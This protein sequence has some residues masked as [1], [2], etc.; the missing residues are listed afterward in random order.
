MRIAVLILFLLASLTCCTAQSGLNPAPGTYALDSRAQTEYLAGRQIIWAEDFANGLASGW[1]SSAQGNVASWEFRGPATV[2]NLETGS[3]GSC[4]VGNEGAPI[5]SPTAA[6]GFIIF[7]SNWWDNPNLPCSEDNFGTGPAPGPHYATL[8]SPVINLSAYSSVA[9]QFNQYLK[10]LSGETRI[11]VTTDDINWY[12]VY[13]NPDLP[14]P[15]APNDVRL[16]QISNYAA[17]QPAVRI[18]FVFDAQYYFWQLDDVKI[19]ETATNDLEIASFNYG[20]FD[21]LNPT[22]PTGYEYMQ[23]SKYP[24]SMPPN[25]KFSAI[26]VNQGGGVQTDCRLKVDVLSAPN[27]NVL[28]QAM[29]SEGFFMYP[30]D[31]IEL[32]AGNYQMEPIAGE[33]NLAFEVDQSEQDESPLNNRD[34]VYFYI[35]DVQYARDRIFASAVYLGTPDLADIAYELGNVFLIT[36]PDQSCHSITVGIGI[37]SSTPA[38][39][40]G[41]LYR[42][43]LE[44][45]VEADLLGETAPVQID[46]SMFNGYGDQI[47][48][49]LTFATPIELFDGEAYFVA[50]ASDNG[51]D[52]FVCAMAGNAEEGTA[53]VRYFPE[54]WYYLDMLPMVRM[55]FGAFNTVE[56]STALVQQLQVFPNPATDAVTITVPVSVNTQLTASWYDVTG[57]LVRSER[58]TANQHTPYTSSLTALAPGLYRIILSDHTNHYQTQVLKQ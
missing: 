35:N 13:V 24:L 51:V 11:E 55:N 56:N 4:A 32:R 6:N 31:Q 7:D 20:D 58:V 28:H 23:Y 29:S 30:S 43:N 37:G 52:N 22:H 21:L 44:G 5:L 45:G 3:R 38:T 41:R 39:I 54:D 49:N 9:L 8:T 47:L 16:I 2:P 10:I 53:L 40:V 25:L 18:R 19:V 14:N 27:G 15:T 46:P 26:A 33:Y 57:Q 50:V 12:T 36:A 48:T 17:F 42:F 34:T 1:T